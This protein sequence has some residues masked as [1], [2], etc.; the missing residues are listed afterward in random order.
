[1]S[2]AAIHSVQ[3]HERR[4]LTVVIHIRAQRRMWLRSHDWYAA[5]QRR[6]PAT[7]LISAVVHAQVS[8]ARWKLRCQLCRQPHGACMQCAG[9]A[10]CFA[11]FH[12]LCARSAG[13]H[14]A[15]VDLS[16]LDSTVRVLDIAASS[17]VWSSLVYGMW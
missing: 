6:I 5:P 9:S 15:A 13:L 4:C 10:T 12:P 1:M 8:K 14:M 7:A 11:A 3:A 16:R 2:G 17:V